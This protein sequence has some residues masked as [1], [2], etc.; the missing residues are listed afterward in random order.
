[1]T[2]KKM[3]N[4]IADISQRQAAVVAGLA[5]VAMAIFA[6]FAY[7]FVFKSL[8]VNGDAITTAK[9]I[10]AAEM[11]FRI[12]IFC[13]LVNFILDVLAAWALYIFLTPVNKSLSLLTAW[14]RLVYT[15]IFGAALLNFAIVL[16]LISGAGYL[17][18]FEE[19]QLNALVLLFLNAFDDIFSIGL[20][21]FGIHLFALGYLVWKSGYIPKILGALL[22]IASLGYLITNLANL[23][24][25]N[26]EDYRA[27]TELIFIPPMIIGEL[28]LGLWLLIRGGI[29]QKT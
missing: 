7:G 2:T 27:T 12:G 16:L 28:A 19:D 10:R 5:I 9:N 17:S 22:L 25:S 15:A 18:V 20:I 3:T 24:L 4:P 13:W 21:V 8:V 14:L 1:M 23:L 11:L 29:R 6:G 26:Y